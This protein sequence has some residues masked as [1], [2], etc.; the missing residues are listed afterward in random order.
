MDDWGFA[1]AAFVGVAGR[2]FHLLAAFLRSAVELDSQLQVQLHA[3]AAPGCCAW[4]RHD[5]C[6]RP[7]PAPVHLSVAEAA[8]QAAVHK[9]LLDTRA[10][11]EQHVE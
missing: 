6:W 1:E 10:R 11:Q 3:R 2:A 5:G 9:T 7:V 8:T 4:W